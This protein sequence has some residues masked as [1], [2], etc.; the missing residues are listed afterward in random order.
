MNDKRAKIKLNPQVSN[1]NNKGQIQF[2]IVKLSPQGSNEN[3][4]NGGYKVRKA[5]TRKKSES[6]DDASQFQ[7][8]PFWP[9][10]ACDRLKRPFRI[11]SILG[12]GL[13]FQSSKFA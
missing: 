10:S 3:N 9:I 8:V 7:N 6:P 5:K 11:V 4:M 12:V 2:I 13:K 1:E